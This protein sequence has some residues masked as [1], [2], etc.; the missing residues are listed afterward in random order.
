M[1][2]CPDCTLANEERFPT[3]IVCHAP[4]ADVRSTPSADPAHPEHARRALARQR[5]WH[6]RRQLAWAAFCYVSVITGLSLWPGC[7]S[8]HEVQEFYAASGLIVALAVVQDWA[9][10][11]L[12]GLLQGAASVALLL[13][14][15]PVQPF[16]FYM[17][18]G[19][20]LTPMVL[21]HWVEM[22]H[23]ANR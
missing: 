8:A 6:T 7:V 15:G 3:C 2:I 21:A 16:A 4:L 19:H 18:A 5:R 23:D 11:F 17:L 14:F 13:C 1:K 22:I 10:A 20:I 9:G 12:A